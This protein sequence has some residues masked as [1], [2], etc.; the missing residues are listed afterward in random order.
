[1]YDFIVICRLFLVFAPFALLQLIVH[2]EY[3]EMVRVHERRRAASVGAGAAR[4]KQTQ[5]GAQ[6]KPS[7]KVVLEEVSEQKKLKTFVCA[8]L[9]PVKD[10]RFLH[11]L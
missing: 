6:K 7:Y 4:H 5:Q 11:E 9:G 10:F 8:S 2:I 3:P 1:M